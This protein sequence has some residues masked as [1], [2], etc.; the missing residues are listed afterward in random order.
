MHIFFPDIDA[1]ISGNVQH[2][3]IDQSKVDTLV[4]FGFEEKLARKALK[5][6]VNISLLLAFTIHCKVPF[7][8]LPIV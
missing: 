4:S 2:P 6:S 1:P 5:A 3:D 8:S 7:Y